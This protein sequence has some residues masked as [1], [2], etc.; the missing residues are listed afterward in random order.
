MLY[1][2]EFTYNCE[3]WFLVDTTGEV[4][5]DVTEKMSTAWGQLAISYHVN[6]SA[7]L[8]WNNLLKVENC[9]YVI[10]RLQPVK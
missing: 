6:G 3:G 9:A 10:I 1:N 4:A 7:G 8:K 2:K 5:E